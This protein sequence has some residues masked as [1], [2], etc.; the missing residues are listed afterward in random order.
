MTMWLALLGV[1]WAIAYSIKYA[2]HG[3]SNDSV[4]I[5]PAYI[6]KEFTGLNERV[7][8]LGRQHATILKNW[9]T[10]GSVV[11][12]MIM[13][14]GTCYL[15]WNFV[16]LAARAVAQVDVEAPLSSTSVMIPGVTMPFMSLGYLW[17]A[18][19]LAV[20]FHEFGHAVA[21]A[22]SEIRL[23][24]VGIFF[25]VVFPG[26]YVRF[27]S[28]YNI[29]VNDQIK[30]QSA[31]IWHNAVMTLF[32]AIQLAMLSTFL[33]PWFVLNQGVA[34][35]S[36]P[37]Y[38]VF[39]GVLSVGDFIVSVDHM[40]TLNISQWHHEISRLA[41]LSDENATWKGDGYCVPPLDMFAPEKI[42]TD[43][44]CCN[45]DVESPLECFSTDLD[46]ES[47]RCLDGKLVGD[48]SIAR[49]SHHEPCPEGNVCVM[50]RL[51]ESSTLIRLGLQDDR[52]VMLHAYPPEMSAELELSNYAPRRRGYPS[53]WILFPTCI[54]RFWHFLYNVS[55]S[56]GLFNALPIHYL[57]GSHL[58]ASYLQLLIA[59]E[60]IRMRTLSAIL[61][62]GDVLVV[63]VAI[64]S[65][66]VR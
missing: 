28:Y 26:A 36:T 64:L 32:C 1:L 41:L 49:C 11:S 37:D 7:F 5:L 59:D 21:A 22:L 23:V 55:G 8:E 24:S 63:L 50:P 42:I 60:Q 18:I 33:S 38:S 34:V 48:K 6:S 17:I 66:V 20:A 40:P 54:E 65:M 43:T 57:D 35:V 30:I 2:L 62:F 16:A 47:Q 56:L 46:D 14:G 53:L 31:G 3:S 58:C 27:D 29:G 15:L 39:E 44:S 13:F 19:F 52:V 4:Y 45:P 51:I 61:M 10:L 9:F 25:A 12:A